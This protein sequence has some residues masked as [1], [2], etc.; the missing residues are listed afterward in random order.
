MGNRRPL[1]S[2]RAASHRPDSP[3]PPIELHPLGS[4]QEEAVA[5]RLPSPF[6]EVRNTC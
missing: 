2:G 4:V 5:G 1:S 6:D 3:V